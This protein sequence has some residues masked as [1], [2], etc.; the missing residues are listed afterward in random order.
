MSIAASLSLCLKANFVPRSLVV[1]K[2]DNRSGYEQELEAFFFSKLL[3]EWQAQQVVTSIMLSLNCSRS[4]RLHLRWN[5][6]FVGY[7]FVYDTRWKKIRLHD[8]ISKSYLL[9]HLEMTLEA[10][11]IYGTLRGFT[12]KF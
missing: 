1:E 5:V 3:V 4:G 8:I 10:G 2:A 7:G 12:A 9:I 6:F 11:K